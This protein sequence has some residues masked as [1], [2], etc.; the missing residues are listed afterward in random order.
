[1]NYPKWCCQRCGAEIGYVG[2]FV[3]IT[4]YPLL[5]ICRTVFHDCEALFSR[6]P[7]EITKSECNKRANDC[8]IVSGL[9]RACDK[10]D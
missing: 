6:F 1:M 8:P 4:A 2:R 3:E 9:D 5:A 10:E 7:K